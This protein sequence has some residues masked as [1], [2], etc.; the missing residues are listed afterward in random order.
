MSKP[1]NLFTMNDLDRNTFIEIPILLFKKPFK[2]EL[3]TNAKILYSIL[4]GKFEESKQDGL[5]DEDG[6]VFIFYSRKHFSDTIGISIEESQSCYDELIDSD[7]IYI[8]SLDGTNKIY[9]KDRF[10]KY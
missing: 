4:R 9:I 7:M 2:Y 3:S 1:N 5:Y 10:E 6:S 8:D